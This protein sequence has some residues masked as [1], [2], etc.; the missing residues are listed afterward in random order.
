M[1]KVGNAL[2]ALLEK[3]PEKGEVRRN[4]NWPLRGK[5][6]EEW[7]RRIEETA[8]WIS[9]AFKRQGLTEEDVLTKK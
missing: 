3:F 8:K 6:L 9:E 7:K 1:R 4:P 2:D 5:E